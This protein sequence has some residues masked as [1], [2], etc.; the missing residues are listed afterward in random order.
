M[1]DHVNLSLFIR[2]K[3]YDYLVAVNSKFMINW[4]C[5]RGIDK[6]EREQ[7]REGLL[8]GCRRRTQ[9]IVLSKGIGLD[10]PNT[11]QLWAGRTLKQY[12]RFHFDSIGRVNLA[13]RCR[14]KPQTVPHIQDGHP[15][16]TRPLRLLLAGPEGAWS[17][18]EKFAQGIILLQCIVSF[19]LYNFLSILLTQ[20]PKLMKKAE[21]S[22]GYYSVSHLTLTTNFPYTVS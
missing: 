10:A 21:R 17:K 20:E 2:Q 15:F 7:E 18:H 1:K 8:R 4:P 16:D 3:I 9:V 5:G 19:L 13:G 12:R 22:H 14:Y 11:L 6:V